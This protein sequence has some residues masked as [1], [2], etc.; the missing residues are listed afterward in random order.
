MATTEGCLIA[1]TNRG[2]SALRACGVKTVVTED[3]MTRA[4]AVRFESVMRAAEVKRWI[5]DLNNESVLKVIKIFHPKTNSKSLFHSAKYEEQIF[6][7]RFASF[8]ET[9]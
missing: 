4:P 3:K 9:I 5:E 2:C 7:S 1:S 8:S 6:K